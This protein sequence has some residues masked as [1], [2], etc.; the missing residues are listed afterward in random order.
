MEIIGNEDIKVSLTEVIANSLHR[1]IPESATTF[2]TAFVHNQRINYWH[3]IDS[4]IKK[5]CT[6]PETRT[7]VFSSPSCAAR[8]YII[9]SFNSLFIP[10]NVCKANG[11]RRGVPIAVSLLLHE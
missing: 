9:N 6:H 1:K 4:S 2:H 3:Y 5:P 7:C 11:D 10:M 8:N